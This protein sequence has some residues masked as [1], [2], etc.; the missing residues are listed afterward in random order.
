MQDRHI[1]PLRG[2]ALAVTL[3][4]G[5]HLAVIAGMVLLAG[6]GLMT[7]GE[8]RS[9]WP[10][11]LLGAALPL[12]ALTGPLLAL[13]LLVWLW[14]AVANLHAMDLSGLRHSAGWAVGAWFVPVANLVVPP[15]V[16]R[17]LW[18]RSAGEDEYQA[19]SAVPLVSSWWACW[20]GGGVLHLIVLGTVAVDSL[21]GVTVLTPVALVVV[22]L[23]MGQVLWQAAAIQLVLIVRRVTAM[24]DMLAMTA[25]VFD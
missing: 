25:G 21:P 19:G 4:A 13:A 9:G 1:V 3:A 8:P 7:Q 6:I 16:M 24:Q 15:G 18:N 23:L 5:L 12:Q 10:G 17:A 2:R 11:I 20:L 14:R 22:M